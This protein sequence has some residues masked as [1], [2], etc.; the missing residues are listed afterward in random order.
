MNNAVLLSGGID[1]TTV[2]SQVVSS[3][4]SSSIT[5]VSIIYPSKHNVLEVSAAERI[6]RF[7]GVKF[8]T[9]DLSY[10]FTSFNSALLRTSPEQI[11]EGHYTDKSMSKTVVPMRN[12]IFATAV[13]GLIMGLDSDIWTLSIGAHAGD[14]AIYPDCRPDTLG[15]LEM[16]IFNGS[17]RKVGLQIPFLNSTK[18]E[19]VAAGLR[20]NAPY[21]LTRTCYTNKITACGKCGSCNERLEAFKNN[22]NVDPIIYD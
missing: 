5:A 2:L 8:V 9:F 7:Y 13:A 22:N 11:P 6:A 14:H 15:P 18:T 19:I 4:K 20:E 21:H 16:V 1:S 10:I 17:D 12:I 3:V